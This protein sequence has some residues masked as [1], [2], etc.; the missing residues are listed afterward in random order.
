MK[1]KVYY[2]EYSL[3]HWIKLI[4][5]K[6]IVLPEYQRF[7]VWNQEKV[8]T[9][10]ESFNKKEF[11]PPVTIGAYTDDEGQKNLILDGQQRLSS[12]FLAYLNLFPNRRCGDWAPKDFIPL[13]D[14]NDDT[15]NDEGSNY[16]GVE[17]N[18]NRLL[19]IGST[20]VDIKQNVKT[21]QYNTLNLEIG[22]DFFKNNYLGF[23]FI[24]P[25]YDGED[26]KKEQIKFYSSVFRHI[27]I[28]GEVLSNLESRRSLYFLNSALEQFFDPSSFKNIKLNDK[29]LDFV[30]YL[31]I[32][33]N[34]EKQDY[35]INRVA[36]GNGNRL[37]QFYADY[38]YK[39]AEGGDF[40]FDN[41]ISLLDENLK[42]DFYP[43]DFPSII[44]ADIYMFGLI[45]F[46]IFEEKK[47]NDSKINN[48]RIKLNNKIEELKEFK[49]QPSDLYPEGY[50][51]G[52]YHQKNPNALKYIRIRLRESL[53][54]YKEYFSE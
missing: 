50:D 34:F 18:F 40:D 37:E 16:K 47:L 31:A 41:K 15:E 48:L 1:N 46:S 32:L 29:K 22:E 12:I 30:R 27:N 20:K 28:Q 43:R 42:L 3:D 54:L 23:S 10:I 17:W 38:V 11:V 25:S 9:L 36:A 53:E 14:T 19:S 2:G 5:K 44:D 35:D 26:N 52:Y 7:Y 6:N 4:L 51:V 39:I 8:K 49:I 21:G 45:Y 24:V 13:A 33:D